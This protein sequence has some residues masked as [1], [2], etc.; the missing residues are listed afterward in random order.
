MTYQLAWVLAH[1]AG[2]YRDHMANLEV[3][4]VGAAVPPETR[5]LRLLAQRGILQGDP[6]LGPILDIIGQVRWFLYS[7]PDTMAGPGNIQHWKTNADNKFF[8]YSELRDALV[9]RRLEIRSIRLVRQLQ[10]VVEDQGWL[11]AGPDTGEGDDL[12]SALVL[13]HH[14]YIKYK[15]DG[16]IARNMTWKSVHEKPPKGDAGTL[17]SFAFSQHMQGIYAK[18]KRQAERF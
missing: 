5:N 6:K 10:A 7:R 17:L 11:G 8:I 18:P 1:L 15:R 13:A 12:V 2:A 4:G 3:T 16:L 14:A 9:L